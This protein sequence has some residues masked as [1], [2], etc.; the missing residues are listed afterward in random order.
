MK[1]RV[2]YTQNDVVKEQFYKMPKF[3]FREDFKDLSNNARV[4][5]CHLKDRHSLS[6]ENKW[7]NKNKEVYLI[8]TRE[9]MADMLGCSLP[10][11]RKAVKQLKNHG[12]I[13]EERMGI[14]KAN[15]IYLTAINL[16]N[17]GQKESFTPDSNNVSVLNEKMFLSGVKDIYG[18]DGKFFSG[19]K[20]DINKTDVINQSI[21]Q[22][23]KD[24]TDLRENAREMVS[25]QIDYIAL[26][27]M[28]PY[29]NVIDDILEIMTDVMNSN[30][31]T[32]RVNQEEKP[33]EVVKSMFKK[34][35]FNHIQYVLSC[36]ESQVVK[37]N[38]VRAYLITSLYNAPMTINAYYK[39]LV[40][41]D[42]AN[43]W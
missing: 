43:N 40:N 13:E 33:V 24:S 17:T 39:N 1:N 16:E 37:A 30:K 23:M 14:N 9:D 4:L 15:R 26:R 42:M 6:M 18:L 10:T 31:E 11:I 25:E 29:N 2:R 20:T 22:Y 35:D 19:N 38:N 34:L 28:Y 27:D 5:Y 12:L 21:N 8:Y 41:H 32:I 3:L 7:I 36:F